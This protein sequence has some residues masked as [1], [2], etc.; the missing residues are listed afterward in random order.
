MRAK[1]F[2]SVLF[3]ILLVLLLMPTAAFADGTVTP[4]SKLSV[5]GVTV[6]ENGNTT[7]DVSGAG[8][9]YNHD[10]AT[11][12]LDGAA[13][14]GAAGQNYGAGIYVYG[15][16]LTIAFHGENTVT[17]APVDTDKA[18]AIFAEAGSLTFTGD[19]GAS[20]TASSSNA[21]K[22]SYGVNCRSIMMATGGTVIANGGKSASESYGVY[23]SGNV[24]VS[25]TG[26]LIATGGEA[27]Y[28]S[29]GVYTYGS[30]TVSDAGKLSANGGVAKGNS[31]YG[32]SAPSGDITVSDTGTLTAT[33]GE[34]AKMSL[35]INTGSGINVLGGTVIAAA[36]EAKV[37]SYGVSAVGSVTVGSNSIPGAV[38]IASGNHPIEA[39][40]GLVQNDG[41][42]LLQNGTG[43]VKGSVVLPGSVTLPENGALT[44]P[45]GAD[46]TIPENVT[47]T[48]NGQII[49]D[50]GG[51]IVGTVSGSGTV[52]YTLSIITQPMPQTVTEGDTA[53]FTVDA[54]GENL[55]YQWQLS[56]DGGSSWTDIAS[57]NTAAYATPSTDIA[58]NGSQYRC[59]VSSNAGS[60][61][62]NAAVLTV[63]KAAVPV[64]GVTLDKSALSLTEG[65]A[66]TLTATVLPENASEKG[67][68]WESNNTDVATVENG[69]VTAVA[70]GTAA[71][72]VTTRD[73]G[74]SAACTVTVSKPAPNEYTICFDPNGGSVSYTSAVTSGHKLSAL[75]FASRY[76]YTFTGWYTL[77]G[78]PVSTD[79]IFTGNATLY[80][81]WVYNG[82]DTPEQP[83]KPVQPQEPEYEWI[84]KDGGTRLYHDGKM[85]TGWYQD[86]ETEVW[87][88]FD[89]DTGLMAAD[90]WVRID[91]NWYRFDANGHM[92]TGWQKVDGKWY[93]LKPWGGIATGWQ[94]IDNVWYYL[95]SDGS[96]AGNVWVMTS[97][98]W[99]YLTGS[100]EMAANKWVEWKG[101]W[102][103]LYSSGV[104]ATNTTIDGYTINSAGIWVQ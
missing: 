98:K 88:W 86:E 46:L 16:T 8:W 34:A 1:K 11:L 93:Y 30:I 78:Y 87:Y 56:T 58:M 3:G 38:L 57:A 32:V 41:S 85:I 100:G 28:Y 39:Y 77:N 33:G 63:H 102:Y 20:L 52:Q 73:G 4:P 27:A 67:V 6:V 37:D 62:S 70:S 14:S 64:T 36:G 97:G 94:Y 10:T 104:M 75:P 90:E 69:V 17:S 15:G 59:V 49:V 79:T 9:S 42:L 51:S 80:A 2:L 61:T 29:Y 23:A 48:N 74:Y 7:A 92:L 21:T 12:T 19:N 31:S 54:K 99:Y 65:A 101:D 91:G 13:V 84:Q 55:S 40:G 35:G 47:L 5:G 72:T 60:I 53:T 24:T 103:F 50:K 18:Y 26:K 76:G 43:S 83:V 89:P 44:I 82:I 66:E 45:E 25:D 95:R 96:M 81:G 22:Y 68:T 71:I